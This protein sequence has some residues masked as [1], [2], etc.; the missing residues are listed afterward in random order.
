[1]KMHCIGIQLENANVWDYVGELTSDIN[2]FPKLRLSFDELSPDRSNT[3]RV[4][5][6]HPPP[7]DKSTY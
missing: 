2:L 6:C 1:M 4:R 7:S 3:P 5:V